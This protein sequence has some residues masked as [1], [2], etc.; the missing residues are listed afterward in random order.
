MH[1]L[2]L[3][4]T[5]SV[6][7]VRRGQFVDFN[8]RSTGVLGTPRHQ[9]FRLFLSPADNA[10]L[11]ALAVESK[12]QL[13]ESVAVAPF[14][15]EGLPNS[16]TPLVGMNKFNQWWDESGLLVRTDAGGWSVDTGPRARCCGRGHS[17]PSAA[18][19]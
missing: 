16:I 12:A 3:E 6:A 10:D 19:S 18:I 15:F 11:D 1:A 17:S 9:R 4:W 5:D 7:V 14:G 2:L 8:V 13:L